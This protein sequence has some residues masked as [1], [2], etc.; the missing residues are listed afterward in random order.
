MLS[1]ALT[2]LKAVCVALALFVFLLLSKGFVWAIYTF[3]IAP[4]YD[5]LKNMPGPGKCAFES[6]LRDVME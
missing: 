5:M 2:L 3:L 6:H 4:R 1:H